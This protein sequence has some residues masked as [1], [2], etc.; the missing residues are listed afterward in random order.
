MEMNKFLIALVA[1]VAGLFVLGNVSALAG[2]ISSVEVAGVDAMTGNPNLGV[3]SGQTLPVRIIFNAGENASDV[4]VKAWISG[5]ADYAVST[6][7]FDVISGSVYSKLVTLQIPSDLDQ[8]DQNLQLY[9]SIETR[10]NG[11]IGPVAI[12]LATQRETYNVN[13]LDVAYDPTVTAGS[14]LA[15]AVVLKNTGRHFADDTFVTARIPALGIERRV[16]FGDLAP[17]DQANPDKEDAA[18]RTM[19]LNIP[20]RAPAGVYTLE[21]EAYNADSKSTSTGKVAVVGGS[22]ETRVVSSAGTKTVSVGETAT[23]SMTLVNSGN[24]ARVY[25]LAFEAPSG[26][27][28]S[29]DDQIIALPSGATKVV[30]VQA[31]ADKAGSYTFNVNVKADG[32]LVGQE[33]FST[34]VEGSA[35]AANGTVIL[36]V[37]LAIVFVV[38][39]VVLIV[40]LTRKPQKAEEFGESYY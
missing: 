28:V 10:N 12:K 14:T 32:N 6:D 31:T 37:I 2:S 24:K 35:K 23:Y 38:L 17:V 40:L 16:Y 1:M 15:L 11:M 25:E 13:V 36:T 29:S 20:A 34:A 7:R 33:T 22:D 9:V 5:D 4:R 26:L 39:L 21:V 18:E 3:F 8:R 30:Q 19:F 27:M